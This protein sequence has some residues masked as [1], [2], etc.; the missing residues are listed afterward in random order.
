MVKKDH[1]VDVTKPKRGFHGF[2]G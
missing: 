1:T 2:G